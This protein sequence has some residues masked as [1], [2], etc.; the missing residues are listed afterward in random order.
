MNN[1]KHI[2][3]TGGGSGGHVIP[4]VTLISE[5]RTKSDFTIHYIGGYK[6][7]ERELISKLPVYY[8]SIH[9]GKLRRYFSIKNFIDFFKFILGTIQSFMILFF[10]PKNKT[11]IFS[12]G[13]F[14]SLP[15]V[16]AAFV[17]RKKIFIH[18]QT[19]CVGLANRIAS[20]FA[21]KIFI[22]FESSKKYFPSAKV[23]LSGYPLRPEIFSSSVNYS[24]IGGI[25]LS[26]I[27][28]PIILF[29]GGGNGSSLINSIVKNNISF[30]KNNFFIIHQT[31]KQFINEYQHLCDQRYLAV[32]F[33]G[34]E[35]IDILKRSSIVVARS[36]AGTVCEIIALNKRAVFVPLKIAQKNE[37]FFNAKE[38]EK[39][40][41]AKIVL[42]DDVETTNWERLLSELMNNSESSVQIQ[43]NAT[44]MIV[45][46]ILLA[47]N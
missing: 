24:Q 33:I 20:K 4:A 25:E 6:S 11:L 34:T 35:M 29:T 1:R 27:K 3:F 7:I 15:V 46:D 47:L 44:Q 41:G 40:I 31:G 32:D 22:S 16:I 5:L 26:S 36:G 28:W 45:E 21:N 17:L 38:A 9:T 18:E 42:E 13:G 37:Q 43:N 12:T 2:F 10:Y 19:S 30:L 23:N 8:N 14:V 39:L